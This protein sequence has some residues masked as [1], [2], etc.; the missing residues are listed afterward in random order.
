MLSVTGD[1][2]RFFS[3]FTALAN[4][5]MYVQGDVKAKE[6]A[7]LLLEEAIEADHRVC[8]T[9]SC[10]SSRSSYD[11]WS[12]ASTIP[13]DGSDSDPDSDLD[14]VLAC[15]E[16]ETALLEDARLC[17]LCDLKDQADEMYVRSMSGG[18]VL[19]PKETII[20]TLVRGNKALMERPEDLIDPKDR[21]M[22]QVLRMLVGGDFST[23]LHPEDLPHARELLKDR[24]L[25]ACENMVLHYAVQVLM[26]A[27][28][29]N[30]LP[31]KI[32]GLELDSLDLLRAVT[33]LNREFP[34]S[35]FPDWIEAY[36]TVVK[37]VS[38]VYPL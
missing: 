36:D 19:P 11:G 27:N 9:P 25:P 26:A 33:V 8:R 24:D 17:H 20:D 35:R 23:I 13:V 37:E 4:P 15:L 16:E 32:Q 22:A 12:D 6:L 3:K 18:D 38:L 2:A 30:P 28:S 29:G 21:R 10:S 14:E 34:S 7:N 5:A 1:V 31:T